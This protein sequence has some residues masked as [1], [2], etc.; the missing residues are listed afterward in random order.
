MYFNL[1]DRK[2][3]NNDTCFLSPVVSLAVNTIDYDYMIDDFIPLKL[4][5]KNYFHSNKQR[6]GIFDKVDLRNCV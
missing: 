3:T 4:E 5:K 1:L 6:K 2:V